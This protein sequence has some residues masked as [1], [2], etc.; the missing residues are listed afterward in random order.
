MLEVL[1]YLKVPLGNTTIGGESHNTNIKF[2]MI[3]D[4]DSHVHNG[5]SI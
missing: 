5:L 3:S 2:D 1:R 4:L